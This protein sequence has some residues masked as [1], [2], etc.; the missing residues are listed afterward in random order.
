MNMR[1]LTLVASAILAVLVGAGTTPASAA[2][3]PATRAVQY[4][5]ANQKTDGALD[6]S[7]AGGFG[8]PGATMDFAMGGAAAGVDPGT[9]HQP[10]GA[11]IYDYLASQA[12]TVAADAGATAKLLLALVAGNNP[13]GKFDY[14]SFG[15]QDLLGKLTSPAPAG[16]YHDTGVNLGAYG[17]GATFAE[18][19]AIMAVKATGTSPPLAA[20]NWLKGLENQGAIP[21]A[22]NTGFTAKGWSTAAAS[23]AAQ[24]DTNSTAMAIQVLGSV[25]DSTRSASAAAW[26]HTQQNTDGGFP[27]EIP[28]GYPGCANSDPNSDAFVIQGLVAI[29]QNLSA[30]TTSGKSPLTNLLTFQDPASGGFGLPAPDTFT[31]SLGVPAALAGRALPI[32]PVKTAGA[33]VPAAGCP[34]AAAAVANSSPSPSPV[35]R[36][37]AAGKSPQPISPSGPEV[38]AA[39]GGVVAILI[40]ATHGVRRRQ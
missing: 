37:P 14:H 10:A 11:G 2:C 26:L 1:Q 16:F 8:N 3:D 35:P 27:F 33:T 34:V 20:I 23:N 32:A 9:I 31:T 18:A 22:Q 13:P 40:G 7:S 12:P 36:L 17:G 30:W 24:G 6:V 5:A 21:D 28:C 29:G 39:L 15:G 38:W 25:G 19:L 4:L